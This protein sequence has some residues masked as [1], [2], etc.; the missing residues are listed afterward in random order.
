MNGLLARAP[1]YY[2]LVQIRFEPIAA[3]A[4]YVEEIQDKLRK[5]GFPLFE[6]EQSQAFNFFSMPKGNLAAPPVGVPIPMINATTNWYFTNSEKNKGY[7][8]SNDFIT[9]QVTNYQGHESFFKGLLEGFHL[10]NEIVQLGNITRLGMRYLDAIIPNSHE[11][12]SDYL[13]SSVLGIEFGT[14]WLGGSWESAYKTEHGLLIAKIYRA[15]N[16]PVGTPIDLQI[17]SLQLPERFRANTHVRHAVMD[18]DHYSEGTL[19]A[20]AD[21]LGQSLDNLHG[22]VSE[23]FQA[24]ATPHAFTRWK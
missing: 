24:L 18:I 5:S 21:V 14:D 11:S 12:M 22:S 23:C 19:P 20:D 4:K 9:F 17:R 10:L 6:T 1:V 2:A 7:I 15:A 3:M 13:S 8:L 16:A